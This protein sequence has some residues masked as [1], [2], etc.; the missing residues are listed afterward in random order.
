MREEYDSASQALECAWLAA[1]RGL[2][3]FWFLC[4]RLTG[5]A[6]RRPGSAQSDSCKAA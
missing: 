1:D 2:I 5:P 4:R 6:D 3:C